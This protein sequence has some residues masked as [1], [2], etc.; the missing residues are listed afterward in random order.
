MVKQPNKHK[1]IN[2]LNNK[3]TLIKKKQKTNQQQFRDCLVQKPDVDL[4]VS[5]LS[6]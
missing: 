3:I 5:A 4:C 2:N 1:H 6:G